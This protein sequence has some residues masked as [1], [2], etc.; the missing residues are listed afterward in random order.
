MDTICIIEDHDDVRE[1]I[2]EIL[3][4]AGYRVIH[5]ASGKIGVSM[6]FEH[7]PDLI[8]CD[9]MMPELDGFGVLKILS[10]NP[11]TSNIPFIFLTAKTEKSDFRKGMALGANDYLTKPFD[12]I[13]LL[14][15]VE[16]RLKKYK[17]D[18][19]QFNIENTNVSH[20]FNIQSLSE[21][22]AKLAMESEQRIVRKKDIVYNEAQRPR[23][24][25]FIESGKVKSYLINDYGK[26]LITNI[27]TSG[28]LFGHLTVMIESSYAENTAAMEESTIRIIPIQKFKELLSQNQHYNRFFLTELVKNQEEIKRQ[29]LEFAYS[30]VRKKLANAL[31]TILK[32]NDNNPAIQILR[33][34]LASI[35]GMAKETVIRTLSDFK[36]E[37]I[38]SI[39]DHQLYLLDVKRL[40]QMHQ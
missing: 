12:D 32:K 24:V 22:L 18:L 27:Y 1:N 29:M 23:Y 33:E 13:E 8:I 37:G 10:S 14:E 17:K 34:D 35:S 3:E 30:S 25:Y 28:D 7:L 11:K 6:I 36:S 20:T 9:I 5:A 2:V 15:A 40:K 16:V 31:L 21:E 19:N 26:E 4:L 39:E 38:L